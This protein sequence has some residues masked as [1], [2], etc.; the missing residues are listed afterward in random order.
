MNVTSA[1]GFTLVEVLIAMLLLT[2]GAMSLLG[3]MSV[4]V[5]RAAGAQETVIAREKAREAIESVHAARDT[6]LLSWGNILNVNDGGLFLDGEQPLA[7]PGADGLV[8]TADDAAAG[9]ETLLGA[10]GDGILGT[11]DDVSRPLHDF[12]REIVISPLDGNNGGVNPNLREITVT[13]R[14]KIRNLWRTYTLRTY[15]SSFS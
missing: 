7:R 6:G 11:D 4:G 15:V 9:L 14:Y 3:V 1:K 8:N 12:T 10:G 5:H 2:I 13:V